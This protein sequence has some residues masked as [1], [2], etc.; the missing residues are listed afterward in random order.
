L[1]LTPIRQ[2]S[3]KTVHA[4]AARADLDLTHF[5]SNTIS[6]QYPPRSNQYIQI[7]E[8][9][10]AQYFDLPTTTQKILPAQLPLIH[11]LLTH[12]PKNPT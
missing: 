3:G 5:K 12:L 9:D 11:E 8:I 2:K 1:P 10:H 7:P 4:F 6:L